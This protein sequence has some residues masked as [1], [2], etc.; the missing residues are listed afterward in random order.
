MDALFIDF[1]KAFDTVIHS[2][3]L[4]KL[5]LLLK[6]PLLVDW[7]SSFLSSR[8]QYVSFN[9]FH[10]S[11]AR[12]SSGVPQGSVLGPLLF[13]LYINDLPDTVST[14]IRLYA[15]DC[16]IYH[17]INSPDD[18]HTLHTSFLNF[19]RWCQ[20]WQMNINFQ[21]TAAMCF[22][23]QKTP[24]MFNYSFNNY[25]MQRVSQYKYLGLLF[26]TTLSWSSHID[27]TC[28]KALKKLGYLNRSLRLAPKETKLLTYKTLVRPILEY[29]ATVW[30][31]Y[32]ITDIK[33]VESIQ[34][35]AIRFI[36]RRYDRNFSPSCHLAQLGLS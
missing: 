11:K 7:I 27:K 31:P 10:S 9:T 6:N 25:A 2:K 30:Y 12:V 14:K 13:L 28:N 36:Y 18:H 17:V 32:K 23:R 24:S 26:T 22:S 20:N 34:K 33:R 5:N 15:D 8:S 1:S 21:K 4:Y 29:G 35:K 3:L 19:C 16:V